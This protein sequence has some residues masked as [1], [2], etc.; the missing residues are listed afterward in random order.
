MLFGRPTI[1]LLLC[2]LA[3]CAGPAGAQEPPAPM[4]VWYL[5]HCGFAIRV[6]TRLLVFDYLSERGTPAQ[7][8][9]NPEAQ[10]LAPP[11]RGDPPANPAAP[12]LPGLK[13]GVI[14]SG[15]LAGLDVH[16]FVTHPHADHYDPVILGWE[17]ETE[18]IHYYFGWKAGENPQHHYLVG[19]RATVDVDGL[20]IYTINSHHSG[21]PEVAFL[22]HVDG[23]WI[24]HNGDYRQ[25]YL[26][27]F[28]Y[29]ETLTDHMGLVFHVGLTDEQLQ[30][31]HQAFYLVDHFR[32]DAFFPMHF[33]G[34]ENKEAEFAR[35]MAARGY[36][37]FIP[38]PL[39]RGDSWK[40]PETDLHPRE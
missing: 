3:I 39:R 12:D 18:N 38:V 17:K 28:E 16:V 35:V 31:T 2:G 37:T 11:P 33:G 24:Y 4:S 30:Y 22:V 27:D 13:D 40:L 6:G 15:D 10:R 29:L 7:D 21:V 20:E 36:E 32:P 5:G 9:G 25:D 23:R 14:D 19:P 1:A 34:D 26:R 8:P